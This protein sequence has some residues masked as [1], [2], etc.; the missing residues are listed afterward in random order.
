MTVDM[1]DVDKAIERYEASLQTKKNIAKK[2]LE[3]GISIEVIHKTTDLS[4]TEICNLRQ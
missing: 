1:S 4:E 2:M 3:Q